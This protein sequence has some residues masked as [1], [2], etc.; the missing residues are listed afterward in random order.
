[1]AS[2][3]L[4]RDLYRMNW[5]AGETLGKV[6]AFGKTAHSGRRRQW[7]IVGGGRWMAARIQVGRFDPES[8]VH[9]HNAE[10]KR[11]QFCMYKTALSKSR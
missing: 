3:G 10:T 5:R 4:P 9:V 2:I 11:R 6:V 7:A 1:M 8:I